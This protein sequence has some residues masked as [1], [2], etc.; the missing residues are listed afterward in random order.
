[1]AASKS[2]RLRSWDRF[3]M[4]LPFG[5]Y[6]CAYGPPI[7]APPNDPESIEAARKMLEIALNEQQES[8]ESELGLGA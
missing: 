1:M 8:I 3:M 6:I 2:R 5:R 7:P 4:P